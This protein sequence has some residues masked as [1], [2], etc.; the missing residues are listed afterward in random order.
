MIFSQFVPLMKE[1]RFVEF[2]GKA[3]RER[4]AIEPHPTRPGV[5]LVTS[6]TG[7]TYSDGKAVKYT[8]SSDGC[9]CPAGTNG[10]ECKH[11]ALALHT[12]LDEGCYDID[13][14]QWEMEF[15]VGQWFYKEVVI[16]EGS[17]T[18]KAKL[19]DGSRVHSSD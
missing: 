14:L 1:Q 15:W 17:T 9:S 6:G 2:L 16:P 5:W 3:V 11:Y 10:R 7:R 18:A 19:L 13:L 4:L 12:M 8:V